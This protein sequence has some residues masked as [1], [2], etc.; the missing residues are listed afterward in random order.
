MSDID[1]DWCLNMAAL[2]GDAEIGAGS[3]MH[4]WEEAK[5]RIEAQAAQVEAYG[6]SLQLKQALIDEQAEQIWKLRAAL[7]RTAVKADGASRKRI[8]AALAGKAEQ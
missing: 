4:P 3:L 2:E 5:A 8:R 6:R 1:K 7:E